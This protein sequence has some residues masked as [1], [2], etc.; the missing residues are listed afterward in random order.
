[1]ISSAIGFAEG[2]MYSEWS[3]SIINYIKR[4][5]IINVE[6]ASFGRLD[7]NNLAS[8]S[9][10]VCIQQHHVSQTIVSSL[11]FTLTR[12]ASE[13][14]CSEL[15]TSRVGPASESDTCDYPHLLLN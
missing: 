6:Q 1:V 4:C 13:P 15:V 5:I 10:K 8:V 11:T 12:A 3:D 7:A 9:Q 14:H 2:C